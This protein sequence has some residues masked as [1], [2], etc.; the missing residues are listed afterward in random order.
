MI[1]PVE[2]EYYVIDAGLLNGSL[3]AKVFITFIALIS[4][5]NFSAKRLIKDANLNEKLIFCSTSVLA[6]VLLFYFN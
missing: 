2:E 4:M 3:L 1:Y 5:V 6:V